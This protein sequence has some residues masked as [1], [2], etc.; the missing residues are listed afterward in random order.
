MKPMGVGVG[1]AP[2]L[3]PHFYPKIMKIRI[4]TNN[5][6]GLTLS[7]FFLLAFYE[8][9]RDTDI[10]MTQ[11]SYMEETTEFLQNNGFLR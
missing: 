7:Q 9:P 1:L 5:L 2:T 10:R 4:D 8:A 3:L 6:Q 11:I